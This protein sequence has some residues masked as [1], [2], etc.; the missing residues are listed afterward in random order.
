MA[1]HALGPGGL[2][3]GGVIGGVVFVTLATFLATRWRWIGPAQR[4]WTTIGAVLG[5]ALAVF[6]TLSTLS[7]PIGPVLRPCLSGI[8]AVLGSRI[9][10]SAHDSLDT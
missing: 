8:G 7:S 5:L 10:I 3:A 2:I 1:G 4:M 9:G 6:V